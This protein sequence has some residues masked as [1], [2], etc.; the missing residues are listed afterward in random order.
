MKSASNEY[1]AMQCYAI[2]YS[3]T[4]VKRQYEILYV[5]GFGRQVVAYCCMKVVQKAH[6]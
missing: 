2:L 1:Y 6:A 5:F 4:C 3:Q